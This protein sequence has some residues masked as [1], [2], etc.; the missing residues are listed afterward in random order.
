MSDGNKASGS[1]FTATKTPVNPS[2][3]TIPF[4]TAKSEYFNY[5]VVATPI[6]AST[7]VTY[8]TNV[9][10]HG[11]RSERDDGNLQLPGDLMG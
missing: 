4:D 5:C 6:E 7:P 3:T 9:C 11:I 8:I 1:G 10:D 2:R